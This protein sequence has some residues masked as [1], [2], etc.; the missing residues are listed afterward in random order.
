VVATIGDEDLPL[1]EY[2]RL[3]LKTSNG[4][5]AAEK[6]TLEDRERFLG[7]MTNFKLKLRDA[8]AS[9]LDKN[10]DVLSE[11]NLYKG[12][13]ASTFLTDREVTKPGI[14]K[15]YEER[16]TEYRASHIL[17]AYPPTSTPAESSAAYQNAYD[18]INRIKAGEDF[19]TLAVEFSQDPSA[20][21][22]KGDLYYFT[23]GQMVRQFEEAVMTMQPGEVTAHPVRTGYGL[24]VIKLIDKKP[25]PG[26]T[27]CSHIMVR[28]A[29]P[30]PT[31]EDTL[32]AFEKVKALHDSLEAGKDFAGLARSS[33]EDPGSAPNGGD[34]G[35]FARRRW[36]FE[37]DE[38]A[39]R[40]KAGETSGVVRSRYGYHLIKCTE[41]RPPKTFEEAEKELTQL[42][43]QTR[44][45]E[46]QNALLERTRKETGFSFDNNVFRAMTTE[47]DSMKTMKDAHWADTL[48][49]ATRQSAIIRFGNQPVTVDS[50][51]RLLK[52]R[53][54]LVNTS[55]K[56]VAFRGAVDKVAEQLVYAKKSESMEKQYP[57][58]AALMKEY[59][60]GILLYQ[61]E[62]EKVWNRISVSDS[63]LK[64]FFDAN[65]EMF[66]FPERV[67]FS[68]IRAINDSVARAFVQMAKG[69]TSFDQIAAADSARMKKQ[70]NY[71]TTFAKNSSKLLKEAKKSLSAVA[72]DLKGD[73]LLRV[74]L[75]SHPD[76][77][78]SKK[79]NEGLATKRIEAVKKHLVKQLGIA[80]NRIQVFTRPV[81]PTVTDKAERAKL[82]NILDIDIVGRR[83]S[84]VGKVEHLITP[85]DADDRSKRA[86]SLVTGDVSKPFR[87]KNGQSIVQLHKRHAAR[88][89]TYEEAGTEVSSAF[90]E[91]ES[92]RL[93]QLWL[94]DLRARYPVVEHKEVLPA[95]FAPQT[96]AGTTN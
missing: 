6:S 3:Y 76:T 20:K 92:K 1:Q 77:S 2:E 30:E 38:V 31:P 91:H 32:K 22:N 26:E 25:S 43:Q 49:P 83:A 85:I 33:S 45:Q 48:S 41:T 17:L 65:R 27:R 82:N 36:V 89:K 62:Q 40:L 75:I 68:E 96:G 50:V 4:R 23:A 9:G 79:R 94:Q 10:P 64:A 51:V 37:F 46:D 28:F 24:H 74:H 88:Q 70:S 87:F 95:A 93:E 80:E 53:P 39:F 13:L 72:E 57:E 54:D 42:Y 47:L 52:M 29:S 81:R 15:L 19:G 12:S 21:Q 14:R 55:L 5:E 61:I 35:W 8:Y 90:Q 7:L 73:R 67:E 78:A 66:A 44:F 16:K 56:P 58:F 11:V 84:V 63:A 86:D 34:L 59:Q 69:G 18:L 60:D 71:P